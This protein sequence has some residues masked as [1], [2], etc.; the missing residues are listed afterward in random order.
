MK[1]QTYPTGALSTQTMSKA[2][3]NERE[4]EREKERD[5]DQASCG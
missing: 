5:V 4:R 1:A 2:V 3:N